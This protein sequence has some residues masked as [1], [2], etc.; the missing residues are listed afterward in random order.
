M[1]NAASSTTDE[2]SS[3]AIGQ[4]GT[5]DM[6][7]KLVLRVSQKNTVAVESLIDEIALMNLPN[8]IQNSLTAK[9]QNVLD[10]LNAPNADQRNDA[11]NK[12]NAAI[13]SIE[14]QAGKKISIE[15][16]NYLIAEIQKIIDSIQ[17]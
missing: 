15:Q 8:G 4:D 9:L 14:S 16:A 5:D 3:Y 7:A 10:S 6:T 13:N 11:V 12:L 2:V 17:E 1:I